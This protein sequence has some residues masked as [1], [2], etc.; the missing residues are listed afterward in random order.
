MINAIPNEREAYKLLLLSMLTYNG[1]YE[2]I[3]AWAEA[4]GYD[5][6]KVAAMLNIV[7]DK[8]P[9]GMSAYYFLDS[10]E[11]ALSKLDGDKRERFDDGY[12]FVDYLYDNSLW[13]E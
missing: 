3:R 12:D 8:I 1:Y 4:K 2:N 13:K 9:D 11:D 6:E 7:W 5:L 10:I